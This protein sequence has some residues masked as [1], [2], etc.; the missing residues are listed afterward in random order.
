VFDV[1][2]ALPL[3]ALSQVTPSPYGF[4]LFKVTARRPAHRRP[5]DEV[6]PLIQE[7]L[8]RAKRS[9]AQDEYLAALRAR[10]RI[11]IDE[12]ALGAVAP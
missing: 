9:R 7:K 6:R 1:C 8:V 10:A 2:F 5:L 4:H 11:Q 3:Q 12:K